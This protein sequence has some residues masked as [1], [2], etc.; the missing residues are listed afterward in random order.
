VSGNPYKS[1]QDRAFWRR[2]VSAVDR[3]LVDPVVVA[4]FTIDANARVATAGSCFAQ[5]IARQL[6]SIGC[7]YYVTEEDGA[8]SEEESRRR[9]YR[10]FSARYGNIYTARQLNQLVDEAF[11]Q[12][13]PVES[14]W[15]RPDG[16]FVDPFRPNIEPDG[17]ASVEDVRRERAGHLACVRRMFENAD[18]FVFTLG[19]TEAWRSRA[20]GSVYPLAP[21]VIAGE[22]DESAH[23]FVNFG[24]ADVEQDLHGFLARVWQVNPNLKVLLTVS[25]V[26]LIATYGDRHVLAAST[27]SKS[28]L[29]V[30][31]ET[32]SRSDDFV[33]YFPSYEIITGSFNRGRYFEDDCRQVNAQGVAHA[34]RCFVENYLETGR[35]AASRAAQASATRVAVGGGSGAEDVVCDEESIDQINR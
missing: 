2:A 17:F 5:H 32:L 28:V 1:L 19:L 18:V 35:S 3:H 7:N 4:K 14:A 25:P 22:F 30:A 31:A 33:D 34:M 13:T 15:R 9:N 8:L 23:E 16:R 24:V 6:Q 20:D 12:R 11:G 29:R 21:G 10:V 26:P 27:Y